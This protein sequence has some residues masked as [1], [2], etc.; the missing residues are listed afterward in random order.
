MTINTN[1]KRVKKKGTREREA[2]GMREGKKSMIDKG[3]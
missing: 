2:H 3:L 1:N